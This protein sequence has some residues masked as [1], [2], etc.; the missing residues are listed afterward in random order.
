METGAPASRRWLILGILFL[1]RTAMGFQYQ[2]IGSAAPLLIKD[3]K[4]DF[5]EI[6]TLIGL[7][8]M[9]GVFLSLPSGLIVRWL[10]DKMQCALGLSLMAAGGIIV[11]RSHHYEIAFAGRLLSSCGVILFNLVIT[12]MTA[13]WFARREIVLAMAV[14]LSTWP[15]G[16]A[17]G[18]LVQPA[19][20][21]LLGWRAM[22][23]VAAGA[24]VLSL[25]LISVC[26]D[27]PA[28]DHVIVKQAATETTRQG[29]LPEWPILAPVIVVG[30]I[31][32][33]FNAGLVVYFSFVPVF[34]AGHSGMTI[35]QAGALVS[36]ALWVGMVSIPLGGYV[37]QRSSRQYAITV[38]FCLIAVSALLMLLGGAP[39]AFACVALGFAIGP[40]PGVITA[41][42]TRILPPADRAGGF[43]VFYTL[44]YLFQSTGP[45]IAGWLH[46]TAGS[47]AAVLFAAI[48][49]SIP[50]PLLALFEF[51]VRRSSGLTAPGPAAAR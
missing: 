9:A 29:L 10:G 16:I 44:H 2:T 46:D 37:A 50:L 47:G 30:M 13:D 23:L 15:F 43:G 34:L 32:G 41:L 7:Y 5:A 49:F 14:I 35:A 36:L 19:L 33:V 3:L 25:L 1:A 22:M 40:P 39:P 45:A 24:C 51:L 12:K 8:H 6:G 26:Y 4:I 38:V 17:L 31:W 11:A 42:P 27:T 18:L 21:G 28:E 20:A 48:L